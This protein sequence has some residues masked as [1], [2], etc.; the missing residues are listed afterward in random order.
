MG[1]KK[2]ILSGNAHQI[3]PP[4]IMFLGGKMPKNGGGKKFFEIFCVRMLP[5]AMGQVY[6]QKRKKNLKKN[7]PLGDFEIF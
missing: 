5:Y 6:G 1:I 7:F 2:K 4:K 3:F